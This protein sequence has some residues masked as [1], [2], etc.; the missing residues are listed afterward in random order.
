MLERQRQV[1][2]LP[3]VLHELRDEGLLVRHLTLD[4]LVVIVLVVLFI[5]V[6]VV[7]VI[8]VLLVFVV[9]IVIIGIVLVIVVAFLVAVDFHGVGL[10]LVLLAQSLG[11][12]LGVAVRHG[13]TLR[14]CSSGSCKLSLLL[15]RKVAINKV[16]DSRA[17][18]LANSRTACEREREMER[19]LA[20]ILGHVVRSTGSRSSHD[21]NVAGSYGSLSDVRFHLSPAFQPNDAHATTNV[22]RM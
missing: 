22:S 19:T 17:N 2:V 7:L 15:V 14:R 20:R 4:T 10:V 16:L 21:A 12:L 5:V 18:S 3:Q 8:V 6:L 11:S 1:R 9:L 13:A